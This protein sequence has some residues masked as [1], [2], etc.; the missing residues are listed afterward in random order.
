MTDRT[1]PIDDE[2]VEYPVTVK[3]LMRALH[4]IDTSRDD[5]EEELKQTIARATLTAEM[6]LNRAIS[7]RMY[8]TD[9]DDV[10]YGI[11]LLQDVQSIRSVVLQTEGGDDIVLDDTEY[12]RTLTGI[13]MSDEVDLDN[14]VQISVTYV[15]GM[16]PL[17]SGVYD[18]VLDIAIH[19][20][21]GSAVSYTAG[22]YSKLAMMASRIQNVW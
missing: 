20:W 21:Q 6:L 14:I 3:Q 9:T 1:R 13:T 17:L 11:A 10:K 7:M 19:L 8:R 22:D 12:R 15:A 16:D 4:M 18:G 2:D 5:Q